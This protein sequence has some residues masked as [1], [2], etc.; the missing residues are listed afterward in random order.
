MSPPQ[1]FRASSK[2]PLAFLLGLSLNVFF[3]ILVY[4]VFIDYHKINDVTLKNIFLSLIIVNKEGNISNGKNSPWIWVC[5]EP[6]YF[7]K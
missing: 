1:R 6:I 7:A 3:N 2:T 4:E 5:S